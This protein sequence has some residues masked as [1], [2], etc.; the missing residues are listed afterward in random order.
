[1]PGTPAVWHRIACGRVAWSD[2]D[3][4]TALDRD[5]LQRSLGAIDRAH[6]ASNTTVYLQNAGRQISRSITDYAGMSPAECV[7]RL[8]IRPLLVGV[9]WKVLDLL[10]ENALAISGQVPPRNERRWRITDKVTYDV[11]R[12]RPASLLPDPGVGGGHG[13]LRPD[14]PFRN[15]TVRLPD[16]PGLILRGRLEEAPPGVI[17]LDLHDPPGWPYPIGTAEQCQT[18]AVPWQWSVRRPAATSPLRLARYPRRP[19]RNSSTTATCFA[20]PPVIR[21]SNS[22]VATAGIACSR[23][24]RRCCSSPVSR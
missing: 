19:A 2:F 16:R 23:N 22:A 6:G 24:I 9:A 4:D 21:S 18:G 15:V 1:M 12:P 17:V 7:D 8:K 14:P 5:V 11:V 3:I 13:D 20:S 10:L